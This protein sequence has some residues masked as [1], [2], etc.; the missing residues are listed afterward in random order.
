LRD[1]KKKMADDNDS[2][3]NNE[4]GPERSSLEVRG[5]LRK[6]D[7]GLKA[8]GGHKERVRRMARF[9]NY[10][11][12]GKG[13]TT[14]EFY[15]DDIPLLYLGSHTP[16]LDDELVGVPLYGL[17]QAC[18]SPSEGQHDDEGHLKRSCKNAMALLKY[19]LF[20]HIDYDNG[21]ALQQPVSVGGDSSSG[22]KKGKGNATTSGASDALLQQDL[23][24]FAQAFVELTVEQYQWI[25][26][27]YHLLAASNQANTKRGFLSG[28]GGADP[29]I[30]SEIVIFLVTRHVAYPND[31]ATPGAAATSKPQADPIPVEALLT[32]SVARKAFDA[33]LRK[34]KSKKIID[35]VKSANAAV[36]Q[37]KQQKLREE[38]EQ[39]EEDS[40]DEE[41]LDENGD[42]VN[43]FSKKPK[44]RKKTKEE[45]EEEEE[46]RLQDLK[47]LGMDIFSREKI[48]NS[49]G[50]DGNGQATRWVESDIYRAQ[51]SRQNAL[52]KGKAIETLREVEDAAKEQAAAEEEKAKQMSKDPLGIR[53]DEFDLR[54]VQDQRND[55]LEQA[56]QDIE[57]DLQ[58]ALQEED[59]GKSSTSGTGGTPTGRALSDRQQQLANLEAQKESLES[60][61]DTVFD[62]ELAAKRSVGATNLTPGGD[63][64]NNKKGHRSSISPK[65]SSKKKN[66][67]AATEPTSALVKKDASV[68]PTDSNFDPLLFLTLVHRDASFQQLARSM[69]RLTHKT[70][71]QAQQ[72][73]NLVRDNF[74]LFMRCAD[75]FDVFNEKGGLSGGTA[76]STSVATRGGA[77]GLNERL[78][79]L[80]A[81][82]EACSEQ[83]RKSFKP[84]L[85]N[86]EEVR[87]VQASLA[88][89]QR[90]APIL[91]APTL[92]RQHI[93]NG[94]F[95]QALKEYRRV[96]IIDESCN[97]DLLNHVKH[98]AAECARDARIDLES[99]LA[100]ENSSITS[101]L[102]AIRDL[103]ELLELQV[104]NDNR[105]SKSSGSNG[106]THTNKN[107]DVVITN[108]T[109]A[110]PKQKTNST[111]AGAGRQGLFHVG[112]LRIQVRDHP[113]ALACLLLQSAHFT[114]L[115]R[116][117]IEETESNTQLIFE[118]ESLSNLHGGEGN[119]ERMLQ[120]NNHNA[121]DG[122]VVAAS[123][124]DSNNNASA[125]TGTTANM[126][127][128]VAS[129][130]VGGATAT[131][132]IT[133]SAGGG[134]GASGASTTS[135]SAKK[136]SSNQWKY[137]ILDA[138]V[139]A[140]MSA[141]EVVQRWL[142]RLLQIGNA[143]HEDEKRRAARIGRRK[144]SD[145]GKEDD[146]HDEYINSSL[147]AFEV[148]LTNITPALNLIVEHAAFCAL[149]SSTRTSGSEIK[150]SF[151]KRSQDKLRILLRSPLPPAQSSKCSRELAKLVD[152]I[153]NSSATANGLR[154]T[155]ATTD[156]LASAS[157]S[158]AA[159][160]LK[161]SSSSY[162]R[163]SPLDDCRVL[164]EEA[165]VTVEKRRC[166]YA[167]DV[168]SRSCF[169]RA[170]GS[171]KFDVES[172]LNCLQNL[173]NE[174]TRAEDCAEEVEKGCEIV[175]RRCCDGLASYVRDRGDS[176]RLRA[177]S[178]CADALTAIADIIREV[179][180]LTGGRVE[181]VEEI[182]TEDV[183]GLESV[184]FDEFLDN[185]RHNVA[186]STRIGWL[187]PGV[188]GS[189]SDDIA[190]SGT[191]FSPYLS[192]SLLAIVRCRAQVERALGETIRRSDGI[193]YNLLAM[194]TAADGVICGICDE[195]AERKLQMKV[196]QADRLANE[197][198]FLINTLKKYLSTETLAMVNNSRRM[199]CS[200]AGRGGGAQGGGP[201]GLAAL[202]ELERLGRVYVLCLGE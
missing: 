28:S 25:N 200:K 122:S 153:V 74:E 196:R 192:A 129:S 176:A 45:V 145:G 100:R 47:D 56:L 58:E 35:Q 156:A 194:Q 17:L 169:S 52:A 34:H 190:T 119:V 198:S 48:R 22:K 76:T 184:L 144:D 146:D 63:S 23:N 32:S 165:V 95:S 81:F 90:V 116:R 83:A 85:D 103:R 134:V 4:G 175:V 18:G 1:L 170:Q 49:T 117:T 115:V 107:G 181:A 82:A 127:S 124:S 69:T 11:S 159:A 10:V 118:G 195:I 73:Q 59:L 39:N 199:L 132:S 16:V 99:R 44:A 46:R 167:F 123:A 136:S 149:G 137:D 111:G 3:D 38:Q 112:G 193:S 33:W 78:D 101:L 40:S 88:V 128:S 96:M 166:I 68:L 51:T 168:C 92:M 12:S 157:S 171:G 182:M 104:D 30:A 142:P 106:N 202:E 114:L 183:L 140:T 197:L 72:L 14:P 174:L 55:L 60:V 147:S 164:A 91:Q 130:K 151:G 120:Q 53:S 150:M 131:S 84:L 126:D 102:D 2:N 94:R 135:G 154:P 5:L 141:V 110:T 98:K 70:D 160:A 43:I 93:E 67:T 189:S 152:V 80:D 77:R 178:E 148:V 50:R 37:L 66:T 27:D 179:G 89:L 133:N 64:T 161:A 201:D 180:Y 177:V 8:G 71:D 163:I 97:I 29:D 162:A 6:L 15:D 185:I 79:T 61:M 191:T 173:L 20:E 143:A 9:R 7:P 108:S 113:P 125:I 31:T 54:L 41:L 138:R 21:K 86:T 188:G 105:N 13:Q 186:S 57:D 62:A 121:A 187:Q 36:A 139:I 75:D 172:L 26:L 42:P 155:K 87:K 65:D 109:A 24:F 19:L 158:S